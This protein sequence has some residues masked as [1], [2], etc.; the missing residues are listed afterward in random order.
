MIRD[1]DIARVVERV[2]ALYDPDRI[3]LFG[4]QAK[5]TATERSD[6][7]LVVVRRSDHPRWLRGRDVVAALN[8][9]AFKTDLLFVTPEEMEQEQT[10]PYSLFSTMWPTARTIYER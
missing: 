4:S 10:D 7:D 2:V 5:G 6:L 9:M 3:I 1:A 8:R